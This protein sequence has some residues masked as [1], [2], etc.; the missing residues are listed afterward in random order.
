[1]FNLYRTGSQCTVFLFYVL[2]R[3]VCFKRP[4]P[5]ATKQLI[6]KV[7]I[8]PSI[9]VCSRLYAW[10]VGLRPKRTSLHLCMRDTKASWLCLIIGF[11]GEIT[12]AL[13]MGRSERIYKLDRISLARLQQ[14]WTV[15]KNV[16]VE[17]GSILTFVWVAFSSMEKHLRRHTPALTRVCLIHLN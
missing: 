6:N 2:F 15:R 10:P 9:L 7:Q 1:M 17:L 16:C 13:V 4:F 3:N 8:C 12:A 5:D 11:E 14:S